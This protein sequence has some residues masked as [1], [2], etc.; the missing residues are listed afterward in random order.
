MFDRRSPVA[1]PLLPESAPFS[2]AQRAWLNGFFAGLLTPGAPLATGAVAPKLQV[3]VLFAS[4]TGTAEGLAKKFAKA[5]RQKGFE[6]SARD[7]ATIDLSAI[8]GLGFVALIAST[9]GEGE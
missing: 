4:Q 2:P 9:Y 8:A 3:T 5:A 7:L 1:P 6:A